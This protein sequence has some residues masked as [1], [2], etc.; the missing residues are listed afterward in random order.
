MEEIP[1]ERFQHVLERQSHQEIHEPRTA[2]GLESIRETFDR[3]QPRAEVPVRA[4][5]SQA[6]SGRRTLQGRDPI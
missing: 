3:S 5:I 4:S 6:L 2:V 1:T